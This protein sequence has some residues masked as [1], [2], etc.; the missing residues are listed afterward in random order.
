MRRKSDYWGEIA[1][2]V[3]KQ[4]KTLKVKDF[5]SKLKDRPDFEG[6]IQQAKKRTQLTNFNDGHSVS[7]QPVYLN[8]T[9]VG[10]RVVV[11]RDWK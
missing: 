1:N 6:L 8:G 7:L 11:M 5:G 3:E 9:I 2:I 4:S 10:Y